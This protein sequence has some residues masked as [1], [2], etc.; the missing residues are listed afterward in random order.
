MQIVENK[1]YDWYIYYIC[2]FIFVTP[3]HFSKSQLSILSSIA[4]VW[5]IFKYKKELFIKVKEYTKFLPITLL[6]LFFAYSYLSS[7]WSDPILKGFDHV[8]TFYKYYFIIIPVLLVSLNKQNAVKLLKILAIS[9]TL[10]SLYSLLIYFGI[11]DLDVRRSSSSNPTGHLRKLIGSQYMVLGFYLSILF[12]FFSKEKR[13]KNIFILSSIISLVALFVSNGR[14]AQLSFL[15][16]LVVL[17]FILFIKKIEFKKILIVLF[18]LCSSMGLLGFIK[19]KDGK[20]DYYTTIYSELVEAIAQKEYDGSI[21][22]RVYLTKTGSEIFS[23]NILFGT[24]PKDNRMLL[25]DIA[26]EDPEYKGAK[27]EKDLLNHFHSEQMD[28]LT[29]Y[30]L[31]GYSLLFFSITILVYKLRKDPLYYYLSLTVFLT[32]FINSFANKTLSVKPLNYVYIIFFILFVI[33]AYKLE[34]DKK[35]K[36]ENNS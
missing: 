26:R 18:I 35:E 3:W 31:V 23:D 22:L 30:G 14:A 36:I 12:A 5:T 2:F 4:L 28:T 17:F 1:K 24:G 32:L 16:I 15:V 25:M 10:Y 19:Y 13:E 34:K 7:L 21:G 33:I 9:F 8:N 6:F 11:L 27:D 29:A 20:L